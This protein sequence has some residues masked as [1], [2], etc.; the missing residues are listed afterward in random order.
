M[1]KNVLI[2]IAVGLALIFGLGGYAGAIYMPDYAVENGTTG[3]WNLP[4]DIGQCVNGIASNGTMTIS[5]E[6]SRPDCIAHTFPAH[7]TSA[8]CTSFTNAEGASHYFASTCVNPVTG[9]GISLKG[10]DRTTQ[11]CA[12]LGG[13]LQSACT[14]A[15]VFTGGTAAV[16]GTKG[17]SSLGFCYA[18]M[19][20]N[21]YTS[22]TCPPNTLGYSVSGSA[23]TYSF[24]IKGYLNAALTAKNGV[25]TV[26]A[27][28]TYYDM[29]QYATQGA[30]LA[31]G[32]SWD[33]TNMSNGAT[34]LATTPL[35]TTI[36]AAPTGTTNG[37]LRCHNTTSQYN[38]Y[39]FRYK[40]TYLKTG[41]KNMLRA[42]TAGMDWAGSNGVYTGDA[43]VNPDLINFGTGTITLASNNTIHKLFYLYGDWMAPY[44]SAIYSTA[45]DGVSATSTNGYTCANCHTTGF[46][47]SAVTGLCSDSTITT[48]A[49]CTG[50]FTE[51]DYGANLSFTR[52][53]QPMTGVQGVAGAE[54]QA[55]FPGINLGTTATWNPSWDR[56]GIVC[57]RCH[58]AIQAGAAGY[59][60]DSLGDVSSSGMGALPATG[61]ERT[62]ICF[63]CHQAMA[64]DYSTTL[65]GKNP[66]ILD[67][68]QIPTGA[69]HGAYQGDEFNGHVIG[70]EFLNSPHA[71]FT[72]SAIPNLLGK[73]DLA[74]GGT[75]NS[76]F[77]GYACW[78]G[79][80]QLTALWNG[81]TIVN[82]NAK[83]PNVV[84]DCAT[85]GG[86]WS[87]TTDG[88][89]NTDTQGSCVTCHDVHQSVVPG[90]GAASPIRRE[91]LDCHTQ[92]T[93]QTSSAATP[94]R[95][96]MINHPATKGT[97]LDVSNPSDACVTCHMPPPEPSDSGTLR[98]HLFRINPSASYS[99]FPT[100]AKF[101]GGSC[102]NGPSTS[103]SACSSAGGTWTATTQ[104]R[105]A[106]ASPETLS[107]GSTYKNA[108]WVDIN[109]ACG[110][111]H[112]GGGGPYTTTGNMTAG[113][114]TLV[115][116]SMSGI[117]AGQNII[118]AGAG[119]G[120]NVGGTDLQTAI[121]SIS[122]T[123]IT[124]LD[125]AGTTIA[126]AEVRINGTIN[127]APYMSKAALSRAAQNI[128]NLKN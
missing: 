44:P 90:V 22:S 93:S 124:L 92:G 98:M 2:V 74:P 3:G 30:C 100:A 121:V 4:Q 49:A 11:N 119:A 104:D 72:G 54:P 76:Q 36:P 29:S 123:N 114:T 79:T 50:T 33:T 77:T 8:A 23:C 5:S 56:N 28:G 81:S 16:T 116:A 126:G 67:P 59:T 106:V 37:C 107:N 101:Y 85:A 96:D 65:N 14:S 95:L 41:H 78:N 38:S 13:T 83:D 26:A 71:R 62:N 15:W 120:T 70:L 87:N 25:T 122:G 47:N 61:Y 117:T 125:P 51:N 19:N 88:N 10:L 75:F 89:T 69:S 105:R 40:E 63:G 80:N 127:G 94:I 12:A 45:S 43:A 52:T 18:R 9:A 84:S 55:T 113:S 109:L 86:T 103:S 58:A 73:Y 6:T 112:G 66:V 64:T 60:T 48:Q 82:I 21:R 108:V 115:V 57:S 1:K 20:A 91:C 118:V 34:S 35:A 42:V 27:A 39:V 32:G 24:G 128:H 111:C 102:S 46:S 97:P 99:T 7:S 17:D 53:W 31:N 110:Q 68:T